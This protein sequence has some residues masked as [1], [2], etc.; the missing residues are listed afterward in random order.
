MEEKPDR[1]RVDIDQDECKGCGLCVELCPADVLFISDKINKQGYNPVEYTGSGCTGCGTC[2][3][4]C[5][6]PG[7]ITVYRLKKSEKA[8]KET[9]GAPSGG[10]N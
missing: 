4:T 3:Y 6:E 7:A 1:G 2:F 5:P 10:S 8:K 9:I